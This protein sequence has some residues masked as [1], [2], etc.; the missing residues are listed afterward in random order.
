VF[1]TA[2]AKD[3]DAVR[4]SG[5]EPIDRRRPVA[6]YVET[7]TGGTGF[8]IV[9][10]TVG[11]AVIDDAFLAVRRWTGHAVSILGWTAHNLAPLSFRGATFSGV[12]SLL[13]LLTG[14]GLAHHGHILRSVTELVDAGQLRPRLHPETFRM[15]TVA[16]AHALL[17][18]GR[19]AGKVVVEVG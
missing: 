3:L 1:A 15:E 19:A 7:F 17:R 13:P 16:Q 4:A 12:F 5:A 9:L 6:E 8:D 14:E 11:G 2:S 10:D 18:S